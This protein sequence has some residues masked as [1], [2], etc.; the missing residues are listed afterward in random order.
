MTHHQLFDLDHLLES[1]I[2]D[3]FTPVFEKH[4]SPQLCR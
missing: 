1:G 3:E 4:L 2:V